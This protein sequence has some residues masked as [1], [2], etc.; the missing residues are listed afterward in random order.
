MNRSIRLVLIGSTLSVITGVAS[1]QSPGMTIKTDQQ[2]W[3]SPEE[4]EKRDQVDKAYK[5]AIK[6]TPAAAQKPVDPW[7][8]VRPAA[9]P[10]EKSA[11]GR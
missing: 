8:T 3:I 11:K 5:D 1:A 7:G 4:L 2:Q 9:A 6:K 10:T